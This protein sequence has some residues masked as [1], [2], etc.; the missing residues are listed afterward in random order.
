MVDSVYEAY[1][2]LNRVMPNMS[3]YE[4][5]EFRGKYVFRTSGAVTFLAVQKDSGEVFWADNDEFFDNIEELAVASKE[6]VSFDYK[7]QQVKTPIWESEPE[8]ILEQ[9][10]HIKSKNMHELALYRK[11]LFKRPQLK[12]LFLELTDKCNLN[13]RHCGSACDP[14]GCHFMDTE[15]ILRVIPEIAGDLKSEQFMICVTGGEPLLHPDFEKIIE[16]INE[17]NIPWGMTTNATFIDEKMARRLIELQ[18]GSISISL[19][20]VKKE[21]EWL[22]R[23]PGCFDRAVAGIRNLKALGMRVQVTTVI[24]KRNFHSLE[25]IYSY[26]RALKAD[27]WRVVNVDPIGRAE[28]DEDLILS[29][30][31]ILRLNDFIRKKRY[32]TSN[33]MDVCYGCSHYL[34]F[35]YEHE[36]RD[37]YFQCDAGAK[38]AAILCNGDI[39][40]CLDIERRPELVQGNIAK[41]RFSEVW[42]KRFKEYRYDR[43]LGCE[44]CMKCPEREFCGGD[45]MHTW[46]FDNKRPKLCLW[47]DAV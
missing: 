21:H 29:K 37:F 13:C 42:Y 4:G 22:R 5:F 38:V 19:D 45:S 24:N 34:S 40:G 36:T 2:I 31:E 14:S 9:K 15:M 47:R 7:S 30:D 27:S 6:A 41:D 39:Y 12:C 11:Q 32:D 3:V 25:N 8:S 20:G 17:C 1:D 46:D 28:Y 43:S 16:K 33:P 26:M 23:V 18:L 10:K 35:E 44:Q